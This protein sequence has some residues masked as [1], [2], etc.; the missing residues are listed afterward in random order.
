MCYNHVLLGGV[1]MRKLARAR[2]LWRDDFLISYHVYMLTESFHIAFIIERLLSMKV[3]F[4]LIKYTCE[5]NV[6]VKVAKITH[7]LTVP[8]Y[9]QT[10]F[11]PNSR[12]SVFLEF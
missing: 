2:V 10:D 8:V 3:H 7:A 9:W 11:T 4:M 12:F 6:R 1:Y 5:S